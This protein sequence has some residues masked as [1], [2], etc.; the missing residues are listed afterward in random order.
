MSETT[1]PAGRCPVTGAGDEKAAALLSI[2]DHLVQHAPN[3]RIVLMSG[4][5]RADRINHLIELGADTFLPKP[6]SPRKLV[7]MVDDI[8]SSPQLNRESSAS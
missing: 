3:T 6:F 1:P 8:M 7:G 2:V 5:Q 4:L